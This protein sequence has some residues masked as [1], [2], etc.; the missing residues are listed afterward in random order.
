MLDSIVHRARGTRADQH[1]ERKLYK[2]DLA[3]MPARRD[4]EN[5][6]RLRLRY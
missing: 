2:D 6:L 5:R 4:R 3:R 1:G